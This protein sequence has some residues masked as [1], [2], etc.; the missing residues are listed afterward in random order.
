M[1]PAVYD[2]TIYCGT[3]VDAGTLTFTYK[4]SGVAVNLTGY[5]ARSQARD[6][7]DGLI[8]DLTSLNGGITLGGAA[9]TISLN[10]DAQATSALWTG[11]G[12]LDSAANGAALYDRGVWD[13][14][15]IAANGRVQRLIQGRLLLSPEVT[16]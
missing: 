9:G 8:F 2:L 5:S 7:D 16:R 15:L 10:L 11:E 14:E 13:L 6:A 3:T 12:S 1:K 4:V